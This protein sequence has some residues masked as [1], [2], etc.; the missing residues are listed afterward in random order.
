ML[1]LKRCHLLG[2]VLLV[3]IQLLLACANNP[4]VPT[5]YLERISAVSITSDRQII[6]VFGKESDYIFNAPPDLVRILSSDLG[7]AIK[8]EFFGFYVNSKERITGGYAIYV[9][10]SASDAVKQRA[11]Q[12]GF[13]ENSNGTQIL[14]GE[15]FGNRTIK[16]PNPPPIVESKFNQEYEVAI[17]SH[18]GSRSPP[19]KP[20]AGQSTVAMVGKLIISPILI[21]ILF[22]Q[23][24]ITCK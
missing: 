14:R 5:T 10:S 23:V 21:P 4:F 19:P 24:C 20:P 1:L 18:A 2:A 13:I 9:N 8:A 6:I 12:L 17:A 22:T 16:L 7:S 11:T 3:C 15:L